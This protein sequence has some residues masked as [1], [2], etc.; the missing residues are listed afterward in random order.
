MTGAW[1]TDARR[2]D[3]ESPA[4]HGIVW[5]RADLRLDDN[6]AW[7]AATQRHSTVTPVFVVD[8]ALWDRVSHRRRSL[9][10]A[11]L[12]HLDES[13]R[14]RGGRL[15]IA[16]GDPNRVIPDLSNSMDAPVHANRTVSPYGAARD[17]QLA[18]RLGTRFA[19]HEGNYAVRPGT[20]LTNDGMPY[21]VFTPFH[22]R[23]LEMLPDGLPAPGDAKITDDAGIGVPDL[24]S[25][26][27]VGAGEDAARARL[28]EYLSTVDRYP[29]LRDRPD[30]DETSRL[31]IDLKW[32]TLGPRRVIQ[33]V[34]FGSAGRRAFV[35]QIAWRDFHAQTMVIAP[36]LAE[37]PFRRE[38]QN[39]A[40]RH[41]PDGFEAWK[42]GRTGYPVVDAGMRQLEDEGWMHNRVRMITA[43]FLVKDLLIDWR[44]GERWFR[45]QL[46]DADVA[47]NAG[48]WQWVAGTGTDAAPY[49]RVFNPVSQ[50]KK[51]DPDGAYIR[52]HVPELRNVPAELIHAPWEAAPLALLEHGVTLGDD[53]PA[54]LVDHAAARERCLDAY[55]SARGE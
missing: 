19:V 25:Q 44:L 40:W 49:F 6:P 2:D 27:L 16:H 52:R 8:P 15:H 43:S 7:A 50:S 12:Q 36:D 39:I 23:W 22:K 31:S 9:L 11:N 41:D 32:G 37:A 21:K 33:E 29:D 45:H 35:R 54:P 24:D 4:V 42:H 17:G 13:I 55:R 47:Q 51:F 38:Y 10:A 14:S 5:F 26:P 28:E 3:D 20:V 46:L 30:L 34:G 53:Y 48:N 18:S 1:Q